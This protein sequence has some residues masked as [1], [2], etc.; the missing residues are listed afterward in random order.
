ML[1]IGQEGTL[2]SKVDRSTTIWAGAFTANGKYLLSRDEESVR[3]WRVVDGEQV[4]R[5]T[6]GSVNCLAVSN[7]GKQMAVG[8]FHGEVWV[9]DAE[10]YKQVFMHWEDTSDY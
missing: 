9:W 10:T 3:V 7:N 8:T 1:T 2:L 4:A 6:V 5:M